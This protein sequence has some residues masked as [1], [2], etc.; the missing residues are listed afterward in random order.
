MNERASRHI[1]DYDDTDVDGP[2]IHAMGF[3][4]EA[5]EVSARAAEPR[6]RAAEGRASHH[7]RPALSSHG[8][9]GSRI[10]A[11]VPANDPV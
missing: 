9:A 6:R 3:H 2:V 10:A 11:Y 5:I 7:H 4:A 8:C 1:R